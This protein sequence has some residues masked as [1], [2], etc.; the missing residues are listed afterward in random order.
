MKADYLI[1]VGVEELPPKSMIRLMESMKSGFADE[2][3]KAQFDHEG[4]I[5]FATPRRLAVLV[6]NL[7]DE[8]PLQ[9]IERRGP[10]V[11]AAFDDDGNPTKAATGFARSCGVDDP[12][13]LDRMKTDKGE[14]LVYRAETPGAKLGE[15][16]E[17]LVSQT[18][19]SLPMERAMRWGASTKAFVRPV[20]WVVSIH[21]KDVLPLSLFD[22]EAG[23]TTRGHR[24][25]SEGPIEIASASDYET[26]L[27]QGFVMASFEKRRA[28]IASQLEAAGKSAGAT[29]VVDP[30]LLD[31]V[32]ALVEWPV[33]LAGEFDTAFLEVP[34]EALI[35]AMKSHQRYFHL[36]DEAGRLQPRFITVAN[37]E[38]PSPEKVVAGNQR[39]IVPRLT[40]ARFF[41]EQDR[42]TSL[43]TKLERL[44]HVVFQSK[45]GTYGDK[46]ARIEHVAGAIAERMGE[47]GEAA[48][49]A[50]LCK[51]DLVTDMVIEFPELQGIM[52]GY[53]A[54]HDGEPD[55]VCDAIA[56]HYRPTQSGGELPGTTAGQIV[57]IADKLDT[58]TGI[59]GIGQ[60]PTGSR[61]PFALRRASLGV[62]RILI[63]KEI[64]LDLFELIDLASA[65]HGQTFETSPLKT[66]MLERLGSFYG[67]RGIK[68]D[69]FEAARG[70]DLPDMSLPSFDRRVQ[71]IQAFRTRPEAESLAAAN[72]RVANLLKQ[73][74]GDLPAVD[75]DQFTDPAEGA[76]F[77]AVSS[78]WA[79][80]DGLSGYSERLTAMAEL[81]PV[82]D[83][84]FDDV[85]V[86]ADDD[87]VR[88]NRL[89]TL[90]SMRKLFLTVAD[91][92][93]LQS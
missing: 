46:A 83:R 75:A 42:K 82:V 64:E 55:A 72:K 85:L 28:R 16:I 32:T 4:L 10:A 13:E 89:A 69:T 12:R 54:R 20:H 48:R 74:E 59:F 47:G 21:G 86:M 73:A 41:F 77:D 90:A 92:S 40:D 38:S 29:V 51:A 67:E 50:R 6:S 11:Q 14:W 37:I 30:E 1:E 63:E 76:L 84:Y 43:E 79:E 80:V 58:L 26:R 5:A 35:S 22:V 45:L 57:A 8:Q 3:A 66:Y 78:K 70:A 71:A 93:T 31:E 24:F 44:H 52:G 7:A 53:Y 62:L 49:A 33:A 2:L 23:N 56:E 15:M 34:E 18:L 36:V 60:P 9:K 25:M 19:D 68:G 39:V 61:D 81:Q 87:A 88:R 65:A 17:G 27:E 91:V